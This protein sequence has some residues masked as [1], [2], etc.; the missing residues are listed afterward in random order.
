MSVGLLLA[1]GF[2]FSGDVV[3]RWVVALIAWV[4]LGNSGTLAINSV[5]DKDEGDIGYL[6]DPPPLP[7]YLLHFSIVLLVA[8]LPLAVWL[9]WRFVVAY[10]ASLVMSVLYS[11]PPFR[12]KGRVGGDVLINAFGYGVL[13]V[14]AGWAALGRQ[15]EPPIISVVCGSFFMVA[16]TLPLSQLYQVEEDRDRGDSTLTVLLS[17]RQALLFTIASELVAFVF[18]LG[19]AWLRYRMLQSIGIL[20]ALVTWGVVILPWYFRHDQVDQ[21]FEKKGFYRAL[22]ACFITDLSIILAMAPSFLLE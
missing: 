18:I 13:T 7:R 20:V 5:F 4:F 21:T 3:R 16:G 9:G 8:G 17:K 22:W 14:Y 11:V 1:N 15:L 6:D 19:E 10:I 12:L 2:H